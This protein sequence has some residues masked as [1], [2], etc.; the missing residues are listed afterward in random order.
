ML[1]LL[2][3]SIILSY[4]P[5]DG[6]N[7]VLIVVTRGQHC[8]V[9]FI[10]T[11]SQF[12]FERVPFP[13]DPIDPL[14][15]TEYPAVPCNPA[16]TLTSMQSCDRRKYTNT[17][18]V[19]EVPALLRVNLPSVELFEALSSSTETHCLNFTAFFLLAEVK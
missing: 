6:E 2:C 1:Y 10:F 4:R 16:N 7:G 13:S 3:C 8:H 19:S 12:V 17:H 18:S 11:A 14:N 9:K 15:H 5:L